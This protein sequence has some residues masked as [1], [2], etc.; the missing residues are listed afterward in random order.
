MNSITIKKW[1]ITVGIR[2]LFSKIP[3]DWSDK[4]QVKLFFQSN[5]DVFVRLVKLTNMSIDEKFAEF[6]AYVAHNDVLFDVF[7]DD[8]LKM[9]NNPR[10]LIDS[11]NPV[12]PVPINIDRSRLADR[13]LDRIKQR[14]SQKVRSAMAY[15]VEDAAAQ[16]E[17]IA[18]I[19]TVLGI[20]SNI[21]VLIVRIREY[22][23]AKN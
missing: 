2:L 10:A 18:A 11:T 16:P 22:R 23:S 19:L 1:L 4:E 21:A 8:L 14:R 9:W 3:V 12:L 7:F 20:V 5:Q 13:I 6:Y 15:A 17:S